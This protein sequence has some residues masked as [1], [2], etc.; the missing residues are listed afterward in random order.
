VTLYC[1]STSR[2]PP[3]P[4]T[5]SIACRLPPPER[6][7]VASWLSATLAPLMV[8]TLAG[9]AV[10]LAGEVMAASGLYCQSVPSLVVP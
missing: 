4:G 8:M 3:V 2:V 1:D 6:S 9:G 5:H 7:M 10:R